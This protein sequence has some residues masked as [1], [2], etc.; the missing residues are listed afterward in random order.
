MSDYQVQA[1]LLIKGAAALET[2]TKAAKQAE[3]IAGGIKQTKAEAPAATS[4]LQ[5]LGN[6]G[7]ALQGLSTALSFSRG[8]LGTFTGLAREGMNF[9]N[10]IETTKIGL[11]TVMSS[12]DGISL[13][14]AYDRASGS[15]ERLQQMAL[16]GVGELSDYT[17]IFNAVYGTA[18]NAG[19]AVGDIEEMTKNA[20]VASSALGIDMAQA[21]RD[22]RLM[23]SGA[24][25]M[26]VALFRSL[27]AMGAITQSATEFNKLTSPE[28]MAILQRALAGFGPASERYANSWAGVMSTFNDFKKNFAGSFMLPIAD[29]IRATIARINEALGRNMEK[30]KNALT[31]AGLGIANTI[32]PMM[33]RAADAIVWAADNFGVVVDKIQA[34]INKIKEL[35]PKLMMAAKLYGMAQGVQTV[36]SIGSTVAGGVSSLASAA[37]IGGG[38][39]AAGAASAVAPVALAGAALAAVGL[40]V[41]DSW[42]WLVMAIQPAQGA[43]MGLVA[44]FMEIG[45][46]LWGIF[47]PSL[48]SIGGIFVEIASVVGFVVLTALKG[49]TTAFKLFAPVLIFVG[50]YFK[51]FYERIQ[52]GVV[53]LV[54]WLSEA[55]G[56]LFSWLDM[57]VENFRGVMGVENPLFDALGTML[58]MNQ[59]SRAEGDGVP[60]GLRAPDSPNARAQTVNDFRGARINV[61]QDFRQADP[62]RVAADMILDV[63]R[64]SEQSV[65]SGF[66]PSLTR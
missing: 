2:L 44:D 6:A 16:R 26:D 12:V 53:T 18:R 7:M 52:E 1:E 3:R 33:D 42:E 24:A 22:A 57:Q 43:I 15:F 61:K 46:V 35:V 25:G 41:A 13:D 59:E 9:A 4:M 31:R 37:G 55:L 29:K 34:V 49:F 38:A 65:Q 56:G 60:E 10:S 51:K 27:N 62:D 14:E 48:K 63:V 32:G 21:G 5:K 8:I 36:A 40:F 11:S 23:A 45:A 30:I 50:N 47:G 20:V 58:E 28:R 66:V 19:L 17:E 54:H 39:S 64:F